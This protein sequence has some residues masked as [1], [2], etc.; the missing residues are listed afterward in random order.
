ML[1]SCS[2]VAG[3]WWS[4]LWSTPEVGGNRDAWVPLDCATSDRADG[5]DVR[6]TPTAQSALGESAAN[7]PSLEMQRQQS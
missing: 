5:A 2:L 3:E 7:V 6:A 1:N 4:L